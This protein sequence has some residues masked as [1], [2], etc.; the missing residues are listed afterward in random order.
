MQCEDVV[1]GILS[2]HGLFY[3]G[4]VVDGVKKRGVAREII[5]PGTI[6]HVVYMQDTNLLLQIDPDRVLPT[7]QELEIAC[8]AAL[9][10][11][12]EVTFHE[13]GEVITGILAGDMSYI[14]WARLPIVNQPEPEYLRKLFQELEQQLDDCFSALSV[15]MHPGR[16]SDWM[17]VDY[18]WAQMLVFARFGK[19]EVNYFTALGYLQESPDFEVYPSAVSEVRL[20]HLA[21]SLRSIETNARR[22]IL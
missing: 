10:A 7:P 6:K 15:R 17:P 18:R 19:I 11:D 9:G 3:L 13:L 14:E 8:R 5:T 4:T 2:D 20:P 22:G 1:R 16:I 12:Y 21:Q